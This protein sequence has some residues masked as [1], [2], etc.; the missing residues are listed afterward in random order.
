[1]ADSTDDLISEVARLNALLAAERAEKQQ[2]AGE[3]DAAVAERERYAAQNERLTHMLRELRRNHFG[4]KS[5]KLSEDQL[6][7]GLEDLEIAIAAGDAAAEKFDATLA[8]S[9]VR[10]RRV[11]R[12]HLPAH[13]PREE[14][15]IEPESKVCPCCGGALHVIG[16][17]KSERL[18]K[19]PAKYRV[20]VTRRPKQ[21][22]FGYQECADE[23]DGDA[24]TVTKK[25]KPP[26]ACQHLI[27][28]LTAEDGGIEAAARLYNALGARAEP[29]HALARRLYDICEQKQ[30]HAEARFYNQ[31]HQEW[32]NIER[33]AAELADAG[34][35]DLF[36]A[37]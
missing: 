27:K 33:R 3:R 15:V 21:H 28:R 2:I 36:S 10:E 18:D 19:V 35:R 34:E 16:E 20:I 1:M 5:E 30:W 11:N 23:R 14:V 25:T 37:R 17:D 4:R 22:S 8:A 32:G 13:L 7:L 9:R 24:A 26:V 6:N 29:A 31:L 12:G